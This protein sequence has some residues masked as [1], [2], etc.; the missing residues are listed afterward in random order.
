[1]DHTP[2][3]KQEKGVVGIANVGNTCYANAAIQLFRHCPEWSSFCLQ[4]LAE[5][6]VSDLSSNPAKVLKGY[7][8]IIKPLWAGSKPAY[9]QPGG[10]WQ[11]IQE[12]VTGTIYDDFLRRIPHD[13]HEFLTWLLDQQFMATQKERNF[14]MSEPKNVNDPQETMAR[15]AVKSWIDSFKKTYSPL[16][17]LCFGL[18]RI[19]STCK[20]CSNQTRS[21]ETFNM[22]KVQPGEGDNSLQGMLRREM[23]DEIIEDFQCENCKNRCTITR[24]QSIWRLPRNLFVV[25]KRFNPDGSK[26]QVGLAYNNEPITFSENFASE[27]PEISKKFTYDFFGSVDHHG[28]H[29]G[30]HYTCQAVSPLT[31]AWWLY[32]DEST[33]MLDSPKF[34][35]STYILGFRQK[36]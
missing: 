8:D 5:K 6:E 34:G 11:M 18:M 31:G 21:W 17:D 12:V 25:L 15:E 4:G 30:G 16:T 36:I 2:N 32:D 7:L 14:T 24:S 33:Y 27:S 13:A 23:Q 28:H 35:P 20:G 26:N 3:I 19:T 22:L 10:F 9:I 1:M 29:M